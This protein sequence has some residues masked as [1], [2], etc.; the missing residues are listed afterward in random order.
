MERAEKT[1]AQIEFE[2]SIEECKQKEPTYRDKVTLNRIDR[3]LKLSR[4]GLPS[5]VVDLMVKG[6]YTAVKLALS[7]A[8]NVAL[9]A[10]KIYLIVK[11]VEDNLKDVVL[12][13]LRP[14]ERRTVEITRHQ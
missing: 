4:M 7:A 1:T 2:R 9:A 11:C 14:P 6:N 12:E 3:R 13:S 8:S 5:L 10:S